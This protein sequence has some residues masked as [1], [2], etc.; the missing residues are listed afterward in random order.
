MVSAA[1]RGEYHRGRGPLPDQ[2]ASP[3]VLATAVKGFAGGLVAC[4][5]WCAQ[6]AA[7]EPDR[8]LARIRLELQQPGPVVRVPDH[9]EG[10][11]PKTFGIFTVVPPTERGELIRISVPIGEL[12][13]RAYKGVAAAAHRRREAAARRRVDAELEALQAQARQAR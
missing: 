11:A 13:S 7:Q 5:V 8:T 3:G 4:L 12:V 9:V 2:A 1:T 10:P 6:P